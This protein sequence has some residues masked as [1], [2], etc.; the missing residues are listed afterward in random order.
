MFREAVRYGLSA[1]F[2]AGVVIHCLVAGKHPAG[3]AAFGL[4][5]GGRA[6]QLVAQVSCAFFVSLLFLG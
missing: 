6:A 4:F 1:V 5:R 2:A 3:Y